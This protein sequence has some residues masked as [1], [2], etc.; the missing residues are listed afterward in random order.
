MCDGC[1]QPLLLGPQSVPLTISPLTVEE[2]ARVLTQWTVEHPDEPVPM[3]RGMS[4]ILVSFVWVSPFSSPIF[5][6]PGYH[7]NISVMPLSLTVF[8]PQ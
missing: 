8:S 1:D 2:T 5:P 6:P 3:M 7:P 4:I